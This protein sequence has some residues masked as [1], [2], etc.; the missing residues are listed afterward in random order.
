MLNCVFLRFKA[1]CRHAGQYALIKV[2]NTSRTSALSN[3]SLS[4][5]ALPSYTHAK[6]VHAHSS[7]SR[8]CNT[9]DR[10][11]ETVMSKTTTSLIQIYDIGCW[12]QALFLLFLPPAPHFWHHSFRTAKHKIPILYFFQLVRCQV[13]KTKKEGT[14]MRNQSFR[15]VE[16]P[17]LVNGVH[18]LALCAF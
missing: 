7:A 18:K 17:D 5:K 16:R 2:L 13:T 11:D 8:A 9:S 10:W 1:R 4:S 15:S 3:L 6:T 14:V 12:N